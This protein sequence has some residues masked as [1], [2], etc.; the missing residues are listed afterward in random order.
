MRR[1]IITNPSNPLRCC[2]LLV[3]T[4]LQMQIASQMFPPQNENMIEID[5][6][7]SLKIVEWYEGRLAPVAFI[8][9][10]I[11]DSIT[12]TRVDVLFDNIILIGHLLIAAS[13]IALVNVYASGRLRGE[14]AARF[15]WL[16]PLAIQFSFGAL[17]SGFT[18]LFMRSGSFAGSWL[19]LVFLVFIL[20]G[21]EFFRE[22]YK[23]FIF[24]SSIYF[25]ALFSYA[26]IAIPV[27]MRDI[28]PWIFVLS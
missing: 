11:F 22:R 18:V 27:L 1:G 9:G 5:T 23:R 3:S 12:F 26:I 25:I 4:R 7:K 2:K 17:F 13:G 14:M 21:N 10:F 6:Q 28:G 16:Y 8:I 24:H 20:V 19:F 15:A